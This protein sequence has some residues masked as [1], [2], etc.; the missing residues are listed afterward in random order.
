M[1]PTEIITYE[2]IDRKDF[3]TI[4]NSKPKAIEAFSVKKLRVV[5]IKEIVSYVAN[6]RITITIATGIKS[7]KDFT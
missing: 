1:V 3:A 2:I 6:A 4:E 7:I 5:E